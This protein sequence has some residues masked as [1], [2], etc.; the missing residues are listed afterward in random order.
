ME[1]DREMRRVHALFQKKE[2][3]ETWQLFNAALDNIKNWVE[4]SNAHEYEG[5]GKHLKSLRDGINHAVIL[6][7]TQRAIACEVLISFFVH[8][9]C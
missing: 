2:T 5:F 1:L 3:D 4:H 7:P 8:S 9:S 6:L